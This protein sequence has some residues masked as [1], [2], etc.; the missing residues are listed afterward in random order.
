MDRLMGLGI[1]CL[2]RKFV[3]LLSLCA[4]YSSTWT[5]ICYPSPQHNAL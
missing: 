1:E 5:F 3:A 4:S 2:T